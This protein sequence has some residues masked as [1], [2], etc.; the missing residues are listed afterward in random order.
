M[1]KMD[2][3]RK[4]FLMAM[5]FLLMVGGVYRMWPQIENIFAVDDTI[6]IKKKRLIKY[7]KMVHGA[8]NLEKEL[9]LLEAALK[10]GETGLLTGKTP[11]L[12][13]AD[14]QKV[15]K[16]I[17]KKSQ[18]EIQSVRVLKPKEVV[19]S[20]YLSI[21][22]QVVIKG[23][24][25]HLTQFLYQIMQSPKYLTVQQVRI[26]VTRRRMRG[27]AKVSEL[28]KAD[29]TINGFIKSSDEPTK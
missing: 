29:I 15:V 18:V 27:K 7:Q 28:I 1:I 21:P 23:V 2:K 25:R 13:A 11:A 24:M 5:V 9:K 10:R 8:G 3:K 17:A 14:I 22:V 19:G 4:Y 20:P 12:A 26:N 6:V 16:E